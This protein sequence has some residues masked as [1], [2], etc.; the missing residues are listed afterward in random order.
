M[1]IS[2]SGVGSGLPISD[3]IDALVEVEQAKI[4]TLTAQQKVL[5]E[6]SNT[7]NTLS[8]T[9]S[10]V[11]SATQTFTDS[12]L[13]ALS[14][15][16]SKVDV[17]TSDASIVTATVTQ[18]STPAVIK[19]KVEQLATATERRSYGPDDLPA[20]IFTN[21]SMRLE[22]LGDVRTGSFSINGAVINVSP[23]MTVDS[24]IYTINN[25]TNANVRAHVEDGQLVLTSTSEGDEPIV[26]QEINSN[27][28]NLAGLH[29]DNYQTLG[30]NAKF[31]IN[32]VEKEASSNRITSEQTGIIGLSLE[33][34]SVTEGDD[35]IEITISR[36]DDA[37]SVLEALQTFVTNFNKAIAD[38]DTETAV[39][40][41]LHAENQLVL[42]RNNLRTMITAPLSTSNVY[43]SLADI[44]I[45]TGDPGLDVSA[46]TTQLVIDEEKFYE[47]FRTNPSAVKALL[48][49]D[50]TAAEGSAERTGVMQQVQEQ[51][52]TALDSQYGYFSARNTSLN[53]EM[54]NLSDKIAKKEDALEVYR[55]KLTKQ[56][57]YMD[58]MIAQMN[59]QF[60]QMQQQLSSIGIDF[61]SS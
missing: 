59:A 58:Q 34:L 9:Y 10:A 14:D 44:G 51:L 31:T 6:K 56:F 41:D 43:K 7:L 40:S 17:T 16:F 5:Q 8:S 33:L 4:D 47:A 53:S 37:D 18:A 23:S 21:T 46:D 32:G 30:Q 57:N 42:I 48:V 39:G 35:P 11:K 49:G 13:G 29:D 3:W 22:E 36:Q 50:I 27:F 12:T 15:I 24:L 38:T 26:V 1:S 61:G 55:E 25:S 19:L 28:V 52:Q 20:D 54:S 45:T 2:F 60:S